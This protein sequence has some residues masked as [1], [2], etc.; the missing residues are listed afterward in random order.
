M[1]SW[2]KWVDWYDMLKGFAVLDRV[3]LLGIA[4]IQR[5]S[6]ILAVNNNIVET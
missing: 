3:S 1:K 4:S 5:G 2:P 6:R